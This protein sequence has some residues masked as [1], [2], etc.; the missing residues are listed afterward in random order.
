MRHC[1]Q[2]INS[3]F[4]NKKPTTLIVVYKTGRF[5]QL[6][7]PYLKIKQINKRAVAAPGLN[8]E[9]ETMGFIGGASTRRSEARNFFKEEKG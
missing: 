2:F 6:W 7:T 8:F 9:G 1:V 4:Q 5:G 3:F